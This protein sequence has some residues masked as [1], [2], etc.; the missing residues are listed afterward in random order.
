MELGGVGRVSTH[1]CERPPVAWGGP[2]AG[3]RKGQDMDGGPEIECPHAPCSKAILTHVQTQ[4]AR[5]LTPLGQPL[6]NRAWNHG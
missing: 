4:S 6:T 2:K 5:E 1:V 3:N